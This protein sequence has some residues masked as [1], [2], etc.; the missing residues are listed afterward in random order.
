MARA[1]DANRQ[2]QQGV[3]IGAR[4]PLQGERH[5]VTGPNHVSVTIA[6]AL[7]A[8]ACLLAVAFA[9]TGRGPDVPRLDGAEVTTILNGCGATV[10]FRVGGEF[11][12]GTY[13]EG[14][15]GQVL[16]TIDVARLG[17]RGHW[18]QN[19]PPTSRV[20]FIEPLGEHTSFLRVELQTYA[21]AGTLFERLVEEGGTKS[22]TYAP[23]TYWPAYPPMNEAVKSTVPPW[24]P[25][26][27]TTADVWLKQEPAVLDDCITRHVSGIAVVRRGATVYAHRWWREYV[28]GGCGG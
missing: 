12:D 6:R 18:M 9:C 24:W 2:R 8:S 22:R 28:G 5:E 3:G 21:E 25:A 7:H 4:L 23:P 26:V 14:C 11:M 13:L 17:H 19:L 27:G 15:S 20:W 16:T 1:C 10:L